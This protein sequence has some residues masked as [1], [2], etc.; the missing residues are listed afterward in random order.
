M[1]IYQEAIEKH[2]ERHAG[3][4]VGRWENLLFVAPSE[5]HRCHLVVTC[6]LSDTAMD[7]PDVEL[8]RAEIC[9]LLPVE[10]P[11][12][13][14]EDFDPSRLG[15]KYFWPLRGLQRLAR[16]PVLTGNWLGIGHT[17]PNGEPMEPFCDDTQMS[18]WILLPPVEFHTTFARKR[19]E[20]NTV[21]NFH[22]M[23]PIFRDELIVRRNQKLGMLLE[24]FG[25]KGVSDIINPHRTPSTKGGGIGQF[26]KK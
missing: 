6:G 5:A 15:E 25:K 8:Q 13:Y 2:L 1:A 12:E 3:P 19:L 22:A 20:D 21:L 10:W 14:G 23:I 24:A 16:I 18:C 4:I 11:F 17:I 26:F 7:V 9:A